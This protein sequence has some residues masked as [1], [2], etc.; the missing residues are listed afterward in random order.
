MCINK[1]IIKRQWRNRNHDV[2][3]KLARRQIRGAIRR[4]RDEKPEHV[5]FSS[6]EEVEQLVKEVARRDE[7]ASVICNDDNECL[8]RVMINVKG[9]GYCRLLSPCG[10]PVGNAVRVKASWIRGFVFNRYYNVM[11]VN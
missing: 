10:N 5:V 7:I 6:G 2:F 1:D 11:E 3:G 4:L 9:Y 8:F